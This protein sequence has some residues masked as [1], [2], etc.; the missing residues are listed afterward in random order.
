[1]FNFLLKQK[2]FKGLWL[3]QRV[4][5]YE[6]FESI[7]VQVFQMRNCPGK[8]IFSLGSSAGPRPP[9]VTPEGDFSEG[10]PRR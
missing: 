10:P 9:G 1:M 6:P 4:S 8:E 2:A 3:P 5:F 7:K